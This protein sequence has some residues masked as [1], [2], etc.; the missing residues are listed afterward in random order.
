MRSPKQHRDEE[1]LALSIAERRG[2]KEVYLAARPYT[3][4][5]LEALEDYDMV[6]AEE[7]AM[8]NQKS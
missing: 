3:R 8:F 1:A 4:T 7:R 2:M 6:T 5:P